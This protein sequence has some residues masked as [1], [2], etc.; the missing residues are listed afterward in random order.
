MNLNPEAAEAKRI[1]ESEVYQKA[2]QA[3]DDALMRE[4]RMEEDAEKRDRIW[5]TLQ[6]TQAVTTQLR[7]IHDRGIYEAKQQEKQNA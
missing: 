6:A 1:L 4:M 7:K 5:H 2:V 3:A